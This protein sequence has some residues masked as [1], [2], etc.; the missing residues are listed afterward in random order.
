MTVTTI[1]GPGRVVQFLWGV[2]LQNTFTFSYPLAVDEP[3]FWRQVRKGSEQVVMNNLAESWT[4]ARDYFATLKVRWVPLAQWAGHA[5]FQAFLDWCTDGNSFSFV[6]D[7][8]NAPQFVV[9]GCLLLEPFDAPSVVMEPDG[10]QQVTITFRNPTFDLGL[11]WRGLWFELTPGSALEGLTV[12]RSTAAFQVSSAGTL[13]SVAANKLRDSHWIGGVRTILLE[14]GA[15]NSALQSQAWAT[16]PWDS[17]GGAGITATNNSTAAP[18]GTTTATKLVPVAANGTH[19]TKQAIAITAN[20]NVAVSGFFKAT[21]YTTG[22]LQASDA[23]GANGVL[24]AFDLV[25]GTV[26]P[27]NFGTGTGATGYI[28]ALA[29]GWFYVALWGAINN[30]VTSAI[31]VTYISNSP[32]SYTFTGDGTSGIWAWG[33][34]FER[35][36]STTIKGMPTSYMATTTVTVSRNPDVITMSWPFQTQALFI[37]ADVIDL[38]WSQLAAFN[39]LVLISDV[40]VNRPR[41]QMITGSGTSGTTPLYR[42]NYGPFSP[43]QSAALVGTGAPVNT[44]VRLLG[45][46]FKDATCEIRQSINGAAD[47]VATNNGAIGDLFDTTGPTVL[48]IN[49]NGSF[50]GLKSLKIGPGTVPATIAQGASV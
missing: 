21:G 45:R 12:T 49:R 8:V 25:A 26:T 6:P 20:E 42:M 22:K 39:E 36:L 32:G 30:G 38:G 15:T 17:T 10:S 43:E 37:Y 1:T 44:P 33:A 3:R 4:T 27:Q 35:Q 13:V 11:A 18:D 48:T 46:L 24:A 19:N 28:L 41:I 2:R 34:Q 50:V 14:P 5:G 16:S 31:Y 7:A 9:P 23:A 47:V 29:N 40:G